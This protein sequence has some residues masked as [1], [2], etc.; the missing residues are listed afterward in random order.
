MHKRKEIVFIYFYEYFE[1]DKFEHSDDD[2]EDKQINLKWD[3]YHDEK[4]NDTK[5]NMF[6]LTNL[7]D[8]IL[9]DEFELL[10]KTDDDPKKV[11]DE[12]LSRKKVQEE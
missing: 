5:R 4:A 7:K 11:L 3:S 6:K 12:V 9:F 1:Y 2:Y 8:I 10:D